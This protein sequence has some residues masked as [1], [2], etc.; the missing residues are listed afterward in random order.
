MTKIRWGLIGCGDVARK[1]VAQAILDEPRSELTAVC[2][3]TESKLNEFC[4][5]F[6]V[7]HAFT[8][9][10]QLIQD[11]DVDAVYIS[12]PVQFH[13]AQCVAAARA[14]KHVLVEKPMAM[15]V[16]QCRTM[17]D[18]CRAS[19]VRLG[20]AYYRRFYAMV[21]RMKQL[22]DQG[23]IGKPL[24]VSAVTATP[25]DM[26][27]DQDGYWRAI[28]EL[29]GGGALMDVGSHRIDL[30]LDLFG[31][32]QEV[33]AFC[34]TIAADYSVEDT[35]LLQMSFASGVVGALQCHFG[36][37]DP[38]EFVVTGTQGRLIA[39]PLN[40]DRLEVETGED[41]AVEVLPPPSNF[42]RPL[43]EDFVDAIVNQQEPTITGEM[44]MECNEVM[45]RAYASAA[46]S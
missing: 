44:G 36:C 38:D 39:R 45:E 28:P 19:N 9:S 33:H 22:L 13:S 46:P 17:I 18:E 15:S 8:S 11:A 27:S 12:T 43:I 7:Q 35:S 20:V 4:S 2:R 40:G 3:R 37:Q 31:P 21:H 34:R 5:E 6:S 30:F 26:S 10:D 29:S 32:V 41:S 24:A 25:M 1:R 42:C 23:K 14:G 16:A